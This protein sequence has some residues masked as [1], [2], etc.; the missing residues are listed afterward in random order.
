MAPLTSLFDVFSIDFAGP[1]PTTPCGNKH[2]LVCVEHLTGWPIA[3]PIP[4]ATAAEV[5]A[6]VEEQV[7][8]PFGRPRV[9]VS[10]NVPCF[11]ARS[12]QTFVRKT[13]KNGKQFWPMLLCLMVEQN[14]WLALSREVLK[15]WFIHHHTTGISSFLKFYMDIG[16]TTWLRDS[17]LV[18]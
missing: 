3:C 1:L 8:I 12:L 18:S 10:D 11:T 7:I 6:F 13:I 5:I 15:R 16:V 17:L 14:A 4:T 9:I 2:L